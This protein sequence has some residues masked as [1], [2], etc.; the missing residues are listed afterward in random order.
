MDLPAEIRLLIY[1]FL[2]VYPLPIALLLPD[3]QSPFTFLELTRV[4]PPSA[5]SLLATSRQIYLEAGQ[6]FYGKNIFIVQDLADL[7]SM[8]QE[9]TPRSRE[10]VRNLILLE[11]CFDALFSADHDTDY[12]KRIDEIRDNFVRHLDVLPGLTSLTFQVSWR[13]KIGMFYDSIFYICETLSSIE[14]IHIER[15]DFRSISGGPRLGPPNMESVLQW[16]RDMLN[17]IYEAR[18]R[19]RQ[20]NC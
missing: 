17:L 1:E 7:V 10:S 20:M 13:L 6:V 4:L 15:P 12:K 9:V 11:S 2:L 14:K 5:L 16:D 3:Q 8:S 18:R 19:N